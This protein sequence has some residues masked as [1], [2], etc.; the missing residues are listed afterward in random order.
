MFQRSL[1]K[2]LNSS[3]HIRVLYVGVQVEPV[4]GL[5]KIQMSPLATE[6]PMHDEQRRL[7]HVFMRNAVRAADEDGL[8]AAGFGVGRSCC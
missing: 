8:Y 7:I 4:K 6:G 3:R 2:D 1:S 5:S